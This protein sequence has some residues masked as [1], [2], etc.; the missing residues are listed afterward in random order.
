MRSV[1]FVASLFIVG[2]CG[3]VISGI[4]VYRIMQFH[5]NGRS[6]QMELAEPGALLQRTLVKGDWQ[7]VT[8]RYV[9]S[10]GTNLVIKR[11]VPSPIAQELIN[12]NRVP[13]TYIGDDPERIFYAGEEPEIP[14]AWLIVGV[15][16][17]ATFGYAWRLIRQKPQPS[18]LLSDLCDL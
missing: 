12:G 15:A 10:D 6:A 18:R 11:F 13:I 8:V 4:D 9:Q 3:L 1:I 14:W 5:S 16:S 2:I 7:R 17:M